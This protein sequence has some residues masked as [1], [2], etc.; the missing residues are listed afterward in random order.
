MHSQGYCR[1]L[2]QLR[3]DDK[4]DCNS[5]KPAGTYGDLSVGTFGCSQVWGTMGSVATRT[6]APILRILFSAFLLDIYLGMALL[7]C[8]IGSSSTL[9]D[10]SKQFPK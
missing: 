8:G 3:Q 4:Y 2:E 1:L 9:L 5:P 7:R 10:T 6:L